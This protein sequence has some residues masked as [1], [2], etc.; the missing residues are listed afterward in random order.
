MNRPKGIPAPVPGSRSRLPFPAPVP[1]SR[2]R[3]PFPAPVPGSRAANYAESSPSP[4]TWLCRVRCPRDAPHVRQLLL[5]LK[6][7]PSVGSA[8]SSEVV[9]SFPRSPHK[10]RMCVCVWF[11]VKIPVAPRNGGDF[12]SAGLRFPS[13]V[14]LYP[15]QAQT[16]SGPGALNTPGYVWAATRPLGP[17][18][19]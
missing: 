5:S 8:T 17:G 15:Q 6:S 18:R 14:P 11:S 16:M 4:N 12:S 2:S 13:P 9:I 19:R 1:G 7:P 10:G 3:L